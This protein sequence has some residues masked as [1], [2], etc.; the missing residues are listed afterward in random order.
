LCAVSKKGNRIVQPL[1]WS[2][3]QTDRHAEVYWCDRVLGHAGVRRHIVGLYWVLGHAGVRRH[4]VGLYWVPGHA[5]VRRH[6]VGLCWVPKHAGVRRHIVGLYWVPGL[7]GERRHTM[8]LCWVPG[9]DGV[10]RHIVG[11]YWVPGHVGVRGKE[12]VDRLAR[13]GSVH[14]LSD[15][16]RLWG[17]PRQSVRKKDKTLGG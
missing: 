6:I 5:G 17:V 12:I 16:S 15:L 2:D 4:I 14:N 10:R 8:G 1:N 7:A 13:D 3:R 11:L 9:H